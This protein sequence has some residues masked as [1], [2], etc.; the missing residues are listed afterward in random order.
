MY[1]AFDFQRKTLVTALSLV[2]LFTKQAADNHYRR[3]VKQAL[4]L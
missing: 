2:H 3:M 4:G 1:I